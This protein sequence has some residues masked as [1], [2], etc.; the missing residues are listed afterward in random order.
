MEFGESM[1]KVA[2]RTLEFSD[3]RITDLMLEYERYIASCPQI[4]MSEAFEYIVNQ[5]CRRFWVSEIRAAIVISDM[6]KGDS[7]NKMHPAKRE[8][9]REIYERVLRLRDRKPGV[10]LLHLVSEVVQQPAPKFYISPGS[11]K[12]MFYKARKKWYEKKMRKLHR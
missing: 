9:F 5:P 4:R 3:E 11:V 8:M 1:A 12:I 2:K 6:L 10:P 7:L